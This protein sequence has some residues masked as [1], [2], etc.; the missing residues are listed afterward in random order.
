MEYNDETNNIARAKKNPARRN[1]TTSS[2][3][4]WKSIFEHEWSTSSFWLLALSFDLRLIP[5]SRFSMDFLNMLTS[6]G[7]L[8]RF[9]N[10][11]R[12][13]IQAESLAA[14]SLPRLHI[15]EGS[16]ENLVLITDLT[17]CHQKM[18]IITQSWIRVPQYSVLNDSSLNY[19]LSSPF[20]AWIPVLHSP[21]AIGTLA[22]SNS[23]PR[24]YYCGLHA[25]KKWLTTP[26]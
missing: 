13:R 26:L 20:S 14:K 17:T 4:Y 10:L 16:L 8:G 5:I 18:T 21:S 25:R 6:Y 2:T 12:R 11:L 9:W 23:F 22:S 3:E 24:V 19:L 7:V 15:C 1:Q